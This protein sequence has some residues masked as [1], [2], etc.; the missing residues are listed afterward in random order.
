MTYIQVSTPE[1]NPLENKVGG[2]NPTTEM[3]QNISVPQIL[4]AVHPPQSHGGVSSFLGNNK[5]YIALL[6]VV[7]STV[8][9]FTLFSKPK[10]QVEVYSVTSGP[11]KQYVRVSGKIEASN[12]ANLSFQSSGAV[13]LVGV[14]TGDKVEQGK[15]LVTLSGGDA[16]TALLQAQANLSSAQAVLAQLR[17]GARKEEVA[18]KEQVLENAKNSLDE[19]YGALPDAIQNADATT[20]D[21]AKNKF[22]SLFTVSNSNYRLTFS[23]CD[24][25]L[26][27]EVETKRAA[28]ESTL[29]TFQTKSSVISSISPTDAIDA[30]FEQGYQAALATNELVSSLSNLLLLSCSLSNTSLDPYRLTLTSVK[31]IMTSLFADI[32][33]KRS[34]LN[35]AK[36]AYKQASR[37]LELTKAGTDPYKIQAQRASVEQAS[38]LVTQA[39]S[40]LSKTILVAPFTGVISNVGVSVGEIVNPG[41]VAISMLST[42]GLEI[43][44]KIPEVDF[45]KVKVGS[46]VDVTLD[47][48]G[49]S[50]IFPATITRINPTASIEGTVPVYTAI[51]TFVGKDDRIKQGMTANVNIITENKTDVVFLPARYVRIITPV[52]GEV[53]VMH[54][55]TRVSKSIIIGIRGSE[56]ELEI[57]DGLTEGETVVPLP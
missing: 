22:S 52:K 33:L 30:T 37:D 11:I 56:G 10:V 6:V 2:S 50:T 40:N 7:I 8:V 28:L 36:N 23:S 21:V 54:N 14:K 16:Q 17:Q 4:P 48:Y 9:F 35:T 53:M 12:D 26:Q 39:K 13:A 24:Q 45:V 3:Y 57:V 18:Y 43:E 34:T 5:T 38:A 42:D 47:A 1:T 20:A 25:H 32:T 44:A 29:A 15:V 46:V 49:K 31:T 41:K 55:G 51:V 19:A 27:R